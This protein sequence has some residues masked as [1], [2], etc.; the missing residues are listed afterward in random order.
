MERE[1]RKITKDELRLIRK[2]VSDGNYLLDGVDGKYCDNPITNDK[3]KVFISFAGIDAVIEMI[4]YIVADPD[5]KVFI[6]SEKYREEPDA[7]VLKRS[8]A[9]MKLFK[10]YSKE[11]AVIDVH[12]Y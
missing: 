10:L 9:Y 5:Y 3:T 8:G 11:G 2:C 1:T 7:W 4:E 6:R 12:P